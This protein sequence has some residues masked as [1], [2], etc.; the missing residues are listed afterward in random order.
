MGLI[1][2]NG[3]VKGLVTGNVVRYLYVPE[4]GIYKL[5]DGLKNG[6]YSTGGSVT[7]I[8]TTTT[9]KKRLPPSYLSIFE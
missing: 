3:G 7:V 9:T 8:V 4:V 1:T 2:S 5:G 6:S